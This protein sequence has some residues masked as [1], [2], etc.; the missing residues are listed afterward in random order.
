MFSKLDLSQAYQ[1][2]LLDEESKTYVVINTQRGLFRYNRLPFGISSAPGIFQR[3][4][5]GLLQGLPRVVV[6]IDDILV[7]GKN[8]QEHLA[9]LEEVLQRLKKQD[10]SYRRPSVGSW[11]HR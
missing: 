10:C 4:M 7:T 6:Y 2:V 9:S 11:L 5:E 3:I 1:Q 8:E